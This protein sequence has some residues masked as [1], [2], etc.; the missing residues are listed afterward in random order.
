MEV[1]KASKMH[2][3]SRKL[4]IFTEVPHLASGDEQTKTE[5]AVS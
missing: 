1:Y 2:V 4:P 5:S 3:H